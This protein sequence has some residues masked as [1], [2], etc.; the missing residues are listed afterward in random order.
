LFINPF[1]YIHYELLHNSFFSIEL[2]YRDKVVPYY[3]GGTSKFTSMNLFMSSPLK[4]IE[5]FYLFL[6]K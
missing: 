6:I 3:F 2:I 4:E 1:F 5:N